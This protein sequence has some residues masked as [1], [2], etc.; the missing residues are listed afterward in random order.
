MECNTRFLM[1]RLVWWC[2][3]HNIYVFNEQ[4]SMISLTQ[5]EVLFFVR[6]VT[7]K[8]LEKK[9]HGINWNWPK[10]EMWNDMENK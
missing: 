7:W 4:Y 8:R 10:C 6:K 3:L 5:T 1:T 9:I 2:Y